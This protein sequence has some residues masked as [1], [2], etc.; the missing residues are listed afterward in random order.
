MEGSRRAAEQKEK[1]RTSS[2]NSYQLSWKY[3]NIFT[4]AITIMELSL[5]NR[6]HSL[7]VRNYFLAQFAINLKGNFT[8]QKISFKKKSFGFD[9]PMKR[10]VSIRL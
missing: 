3:F 1:H 9:F 4:A 10:M 2:G 5:R 7:A 8:S 6:S